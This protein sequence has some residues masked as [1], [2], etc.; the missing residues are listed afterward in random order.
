ME[1]PFFKQLGT[2]LGYYPKALS[3]IFDNGLWFYFIFPLILNLLL[4]F[5][6][7]STI[8]FISDSLSDKI[9]FWIFGQ[10]TD[11]LSW[12]LKFFEWLIEHI[13]YLLFLF[14]LT[15]F[16]GY[17]TIIILSPVL[18]F[19]SEKTAEI[20]TGEKVPFDILQF[21]RDIVRAVLITFRNMFLQ[22]GLTIALMFLNIIPIIGSIAAFVGNLLVSSYFYGF[23]FIDYSN[24]R[25]KLSVRES[26]KFVRKNKGL[27]VGLGIV[28]SFCFYVPFIGVIIASFL[29]VVSTVAAT[30]AVLEKDKST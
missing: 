21:T 30:L 11:T 20:V 6:G 24:E 2:G 7:L 18:T 14:L 8:G 23:S 13:L 29:A 27:S 16:G 9:I 5:L 1:K 4:F 15:S 17:I 28:F 12:F 3:F 10:E 22:L 26:V 25:N 19:L